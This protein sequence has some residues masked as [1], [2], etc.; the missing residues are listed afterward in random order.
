MKNKLKINKNSIKELIIWITVGFFLLFITEYIQRKNLTNIITFAKDRT[1]AFVINLLIILIITSITF[2]LKRKKTAYFLISVII[3]AVSLISAIMT[4][5]RGTP[6]TY[7]DI[8]SIKDG[9]SIANKYITVP[10][11]IGAVVIIVL[12]IAITVYLLKK[13]KN[14]KRIINLTNIIIGIG[15]IVVF[16]INLVSLRER[17]ILDVLRW[18]LKESYYHNGF[19]YS[20][21]DSGFGYIRKKP[22]D[23]NKVQ[24]EKIKNEVNSTTAMHTSNTDI[25]NKSKTPNLIFVQ[26]ESFIDPT[27]IKE[28]KFSQDPIPNFR[29][30]SKESLSGYINVPVT[31]GGTARTEFEVLTGNNFDYLIPG[32]IPYDSFVK[33]KS[34]NS[35]ATTLKQQGYQTT[36]MHNF[37]G[38]FYNRNNAFENLGFDSFVSMEY[39]QNLEDTFLGWRKDM[40]LLD[41]IQKSIKQ[42]DKPDLVYA[43]AVEGHGKYPDYDKGLDLPIKVETSLSEQD[44][45]QLYHYANLLKGTDDFIGELIEVVD[46]EKEDTMV[47]FYSDH[48][49][50]LNVFSDDDFYLDKYEVPY[51]VYANFNIPKEKL[52]LESYQLSTLAM[53]LSNLEYGPIETIHATKGNSEEYQRE[54]ELIQYDMLFG[55]KYYLSEKDKVKDNDM[56]MGLDDIIIESV[57]NGDEKIII[58]GENFNQSSYA[59]VNGKKVE[60]KLIDSTKLEVNNVKQVKNVVVK[61]LGKYDAP[62]GESNEFTRE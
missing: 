45:Y 25:E 13:E 32:E 57:E 2:V 31:G 59:Y 28:A 22:E 27:L 39:M 61:Q 48:T 19:V 38:N 9:L 4:K 7:S 44:K 50:A 34:I 35:I 29:K 60:T 40:V 8:F 5:L 42:N 49:P 12:T 54:L 41:Y 1:N 24:I 23:Y 47:V 37:Q 46:K 16:S 62:L 20:I 43:I 14:K 26:L 56:K 21:L 3:I 18:D 15:V 30:L 51:A 58:N 55:K 17:K 10:M 36:I 33:E 53:G 52:N 11:I 6:L